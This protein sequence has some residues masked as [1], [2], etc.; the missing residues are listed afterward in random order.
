MILFDGTH[1][2]STVSVED[3]D[4]MAVKRM[5]MDPMWLD[6]EEDHPHYD[7]FPGEMMRKV[8]ALIEDGEIERCSSRDL[9]VRCFRGGGVD[10]WGSSRGS[11]TDCGVLS[12]ARCWKIL[13][14]RSSPS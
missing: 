10:E 9:V 11:G 7:V 5:G 6:G 13:P 8:E 14:T 1:L 2:A 12:R 3:L 4:E